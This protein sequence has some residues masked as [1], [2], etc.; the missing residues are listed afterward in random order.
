MRRVLVLLAVARGEAMT[1]IAKRW[2]IARQSVY[3]WTVAFLAA[4][5]DSL[6][7]KRPSGRPPRLTPKQRAELQEVLKAGPQAAGYRS[8]C[9]TTVL[10]QQLI[11]QR[12]GVLY[13]RQYVADLLHGLGFSYSCSAKD[14][15]TMRA[16]VPPTSSPD[17]RRP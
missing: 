4:G 9:W 16:R 8:A 10:I 11:S 2:D 13:S 1:Q 15:D 3:N 6:P 17:N 12:F 14:L 7:Y 5:L